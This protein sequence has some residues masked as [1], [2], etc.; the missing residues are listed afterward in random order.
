MG[1]RGRMPLMP[2]YT[3]GLG[4]SS[5]SFPLVAP[6]PLSKCTSSS[7]VRGGPTTPSPPGPTSTTVWNS[8]TLFLLSTILCVTL[9]TR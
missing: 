8:R 2:F 6:S 5:D 9:G 1:V 3:K 4:P 7:L